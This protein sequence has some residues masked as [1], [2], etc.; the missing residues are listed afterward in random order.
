MAKTGT[1]TDYAGEELYRGD[2]VAYATRFANMVRMTDAVVER[3]TARKVGGRLRPM[4][5]VRPTGEESG[6]VKRKTRHSQWI[7]AEH[8]R[9]VCPADALPAR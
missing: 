1:V 6:F 3:V 4:L 8:V 7:A 2:L 5:L 9:L